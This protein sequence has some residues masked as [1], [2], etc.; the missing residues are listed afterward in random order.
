MEK[1]NRNSWNRGTRF[2]TGSL[3]FAAACGLAAVVLSLAFA[4]APAWAHSHDEDR[5]KKK[6][7]A[8]KGMEMGACER[9]VMVTAEAETQ[10]GGAHYK[11][12]MPKKSGMAGMKGMNMGKGTKKPIKMAGMK[13]MEGAHG[14]HDSKTGG[15]LF[16]AP[17]ELHHIEGA[18]SAGCGF[19]V[20]V[21]NA[22]TKPIR[23]GRFRAF[24]K[25]SG[26]IDDDEVETVRFLSPNREKTLLETGLPHGL[27]GPFEVE[28]YIKFPEGEAVEIFNFAVDEHGKIS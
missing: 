27:K 9:M 25:V 11:G 26:E 21:Y 3:P 19:Q 16:M 10:V 1:T 17:N 7:G 2:E 28:L 6:M 24:I 22:F 12:P 4:A 20:S 14:D 5:G 18:Y 15:V 23:V 13:A 8:M